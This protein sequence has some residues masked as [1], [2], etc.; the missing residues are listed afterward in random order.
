M[1]A[2]QD[3]NK[4]PK[5]AVTPQFGRTS[6]KI[7]QRKVT[8][9]EEAGKKAAVSAARCL[10]IHAMSINMFKAAN[11]LDMSASNIRQRESNKTSRSRNFSAISS[12]VGTHGDIPM[13]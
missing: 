1:P 3:V 7:P 11:G 2:R 12:K 6:F 13:L 4:P 8:S 9:A 10:H 5:S